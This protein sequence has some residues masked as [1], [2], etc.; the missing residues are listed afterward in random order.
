MKTPHHAAISTVLPLVDG[1]PRRLVHGVFSAVMRQKWALPDVPHLPA[2]VA[3]RWRKAWGEEIGAAAEPLGGGPP[4][5]AL[6][7]EPPAELAGISLMPNHLRLARGT[8][9]AG[10]A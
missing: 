4:P 5:I 3:E 2:G 9:V 1:G 7:G 8:A 10:L 6:I